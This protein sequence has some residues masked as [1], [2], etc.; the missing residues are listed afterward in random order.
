MNIRQKHLRQPDFVD[1]IHFVD[2][3]ATLA[4]VPHFLKKPHIDM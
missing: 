1:I 2:D 3:E 4:N